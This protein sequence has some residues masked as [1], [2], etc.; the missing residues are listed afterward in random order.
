MAASTPYFDA[1]FN[2]NFDEKKAQTVEIKDVSFIGL[3]NVVQSIYS[4][5]I[6]INAENIA[7]ILPAAHL[8]QTTD[9][10]QDCK[11]WMTKHIS[12]DNCFDFLRLAERYNIE[13]VETAITE[14]VLKNFEAVS[15][16]ESF[17][18]ISQGALC[19]YLSADVLKTSMNEYAVYQAAKYWILK[20][21]INDITLISNI[22][23]NVR[24]ALVPAM[25]LSDQIL[26][27]DFIEGNK[28]FR[29]MVS[30]AMK[31]HADVFSQPFYQGNMNKPRGKKG[32]LVIPNGKQE[33][34]NTYVAYSNGHINF[35]PFPT[36]QSTKKSK[37]LNIPI[38]YDSMSAVQVNNFLFLFGCTSDGFHNFTMRYDGS[39]DT[40]IKLEPVPQ[41]A[42]VGSKV[43]CTEDRSQILL[44]GGMCVHADS[45]FTL[46]SNE[47][48]EYTNI[49]DVKKNAWSSGIDLPQGLVHMGVATVNGLVF[50]TGG[51]CASGQTSDK[52]FAYDVKANLWLTKAKMNEK[53]CYH[54]L[55]AIGE[56]LYAVGGRDARGSDSSSIDIYDVLS[57]QWTQIPLPVGERFVAASS[58]VDGHRIF[59]GGGIENGKKIRIYD[60]DKNKI[61]AVDVSSCIARNVSAFL[62]LPKL[63]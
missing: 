4:N 5:Q 12:K 51:H 56:K 59:I 40:W 23:S 57:N 42:T 21:N 54:T 63:L 50:V 16:T 25:T 48:V 45:K 33:H 7:D 43:A 32:L 19:R 39:N 24:F 60:V 6:D 58:V 36:L 30:E 61:T 11:K 37:S 18:G 17:T 29:K 46:P 47:I 35:L 9:I 10:V 31:Y 22:M 34:D 26:M 28:P 55:D 49:Y 3:K 41:D 62:T 20:N 38:V 44:M 14:F 13:S 27:D 52:T 15:Q 53:R 1:M 8:M 2:G